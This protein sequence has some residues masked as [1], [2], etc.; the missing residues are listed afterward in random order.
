MSETMDRAAIAAEAFKQQP[1][2]ADLEAVRAYWRDVT[3]GQDQADR[4]DWSAEQAGAVAHAAAGALVLDQD[5]TPRHV[6]GTGLGRRVA[7]GRIAVLRTAGFLAASAPDATGRRL[8]E[9]TPDGHRALMVWQ[10]WSPAPV[11]KDKRTERD[12]LTPLHQGDEARRRAVAAARRMREYER[13]NAA[14]WA[15]TEAKIAAGRRE[16][17]LNAQWREANGIRNPWAKR[18]AGWTIEAQAEADRAAEETAEAAPRETA[19]VCEV[20][21]P[22]PEPAAHG[23]AAGAEQVRQQAEDTDQPQRTAAAGALAE[24][25]PEAHMP[26]VTGSPTRRRQSHGTDRDLRIAARRH[27]YG[28]IS[29]RA[30]PWRSAT[31]APSSRRT[32]RTTSRRTTMTTAAGTVRR[33][34]AHHVG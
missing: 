24:L 31:T 4:L 2:S 13:R 3:L 15:E 30:R 12:A 34:E 6:T 29:S 17:E 33:E 1:D 16:D 22:E 18:P 26:Q 27:S 19:H 21:E 32:R 20:R 10:R 9:P 8:I 25:T 28:S 5:G 7:A 11:V 14:K 23:R